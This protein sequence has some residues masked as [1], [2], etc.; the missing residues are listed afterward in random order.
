[1]QQKWQ[2][3]ALSRANL[4]KIPLLGGLTRQSVQTRINRMNPIGKAFLAQTT[5]ILLADAVLPRPPK[6]MAIVND[7]N[8][9]WTKSK[10]DR[11]RWRKNAQAF[12]RSLTAD[13]I[14]AYFDPKTGEL[15]AVIPPHLRLN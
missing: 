1:M 8:E 10:P 3:F 12:E 2:R 5:L 7:D 14:G 6:S 11:V 4:S 13:R 9:F 15:L